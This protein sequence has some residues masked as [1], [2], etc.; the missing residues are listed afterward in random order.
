MGHVYKGF[1]DPISV[2]LRLS[3][4]RKGE[5]QTRKRLTRRV[6]PRLLAPILS[7]DHQGPLFL[8]VRDRDRSDSTVIPEIG[9]YLQVHQLLLDNFY[10]VI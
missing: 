8:A 10:P 9:T 4:D 7:R 1:A 3:K 5:T 2:G 6:R